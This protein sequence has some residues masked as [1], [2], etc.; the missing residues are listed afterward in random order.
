MG[1]VPS[2][3]KHLD[4]D[5]CIQ[6]YHLGI[7][8]I[9]CACIILL[10]PKAAPTNVVVAP[11]SNSL[12]V[13][14]NRPKSGVPGVIRGYVVQCVRHAGGGDPQQNVTVNFTTTSYE[15]QGLVHSTTYRIRVLA[16]TVL[17]GPFSEPLYIS[18]LEPSLTGAVNTF[19]VS[20]II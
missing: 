10:A 19:F 8:T 13:Q 12:Y 5:P 11:S 15:F 18:T 3:T 6:L 17:P 9:S 14:W 4:S 16:F 1:L 2:W 7:T 20:S